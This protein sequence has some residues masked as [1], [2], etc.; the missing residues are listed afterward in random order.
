MKP[1]ELTGQTFGR[2]TVLGKSKKCR[3]EPLWLCRCSCGNLCEVTGSNLKRGKQKS[4]GCL[5]ADNLRSI[6]RKHGMTKTRLFYIWS[7]MIQRCSNPNNRSYPNYGGRGIKVCE[8]WTN[9]FESFSS[10]AAQSG[11]DD[12]LTLDRIDNNLGYFPE[13]CRWASFK[14][15]Q[16]NRRDNIVVEIMGQSKTLSQW[17]EL[18]GVKSGTIWWR[19]KAG[20]RGL[21][22]IAPVKKP[23]TEDEINER[24]S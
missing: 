20:K 18:Y 16:N 7:S 12:S 11:Y 14:A 10:W 2:L 9:S 8:D 23:E 24:N 19:Y 6:T 15:Q 4:C 3:K 13:N 17:G 5:R 1:L 21:E 22:L